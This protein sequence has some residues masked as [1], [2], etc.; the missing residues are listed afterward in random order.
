MVVVLV[1]VEVGSRSRTRTHAAPKIGTV[2]VWCLTL[3]AGVYGGDDIF[4]PCT[5]AS[6]RGR[7]MLIVTDINK[8]CR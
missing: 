2:G 4:S 7:S 6:T 5:L 8:S 3:D 1:V